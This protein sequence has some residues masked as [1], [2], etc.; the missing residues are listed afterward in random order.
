MK[1][2]INQTIPQRQVSLY[3]D[4]YTYF[5]VRKLRE[6]TD[7]ISEQVRFIRKMEGQHYFKYIAGNPKHG[8]NIRPIF[9]YV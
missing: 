5:G 1:I 4:K 2:P 6:A 8:N 7:V 9:M 3:T